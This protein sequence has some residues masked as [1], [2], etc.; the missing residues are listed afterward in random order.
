MKKN[1]SFPVK[2]KG[3]T[4][5]FHGNPVPVS[6]GITLEQLAAICRHVHNFRKPEKRLTIAPNSSP[7]AIIGTSLH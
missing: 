3:Y 2:R 5:I 6:S 1:F 4:L 7:L